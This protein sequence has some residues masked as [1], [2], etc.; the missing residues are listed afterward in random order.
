VIGY[1]GHYPFGESSY[2]NNGNDLV[3]TSYQR[4]AE[5]GLDYAMVRYYD[6][7]ARFCSADPVGGQ[8]NDPQTWNR[9]TYVRNDP[10]NLT[11]PNG[12]S[13]F[14][15]FIDA[16]IGALAIALPEIDPALFSFMGDTLMATTTT[17]T[18]VETASINGTIISSGAQIF[19]TVTLANI[20]TTALGFGA[21]AATAAQA[22]QVQTPQQ[23]Q[24]V[25]TDCPKVPPHPKDADVNANIRKTVEMDAKA[26]ATQTPRVRVWQ[27]FISQVKPGGLWDYKAQ[28]PGFQ[29]YDDF[30]NFNYGA[31]GSTLTSDEKVLFQ[32][33]AA[34]RYS[35]NG[36]PLPGLRKYGSPL[37][38]PNYGND[39]HKNEMIRQGMKYQQNGCGNS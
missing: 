31:T 15:W 26:A 28:P 27:W 30:G 18:A 7:T 8:V 16:I 11:D 2:S 34:A 5:S 13:W 39:P 23:P 29:A 25:K 37:K 24:Q 22:S 4:D 32:G 35:A 6:S 1:Q 9:Y 17:Q 33:A 12:E 14:S 10:I 38:G 3:F 21:A 20:S 19:Q 36:S